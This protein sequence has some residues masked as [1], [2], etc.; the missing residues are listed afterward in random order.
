MAQKTYLMSCVKSTYSGTPAFRKAFHVSPDLSQRAPGPAPIPAPGE[1]SLFGLYAPVSFKSGLTYMMNVD[2]HGTCDSFQSSLLS[3]LVE[4]KVLI[5]RAD[6]TFDSI[7]SIC[8]FLSRNVM[9]NEIDEAEPCHHPF[10]LN[11]V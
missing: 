6:K 11:C 7:S 4:G 10:F 8:L 5:L 2:M 3:W 1:E 9:G